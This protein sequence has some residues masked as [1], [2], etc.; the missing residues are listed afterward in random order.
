MSYFYTILT[1]KSSSLLPI[2]IV[3]VM[4]LNLFLIPP[5]GYPVYV[6]GGS[7]IIILIVFSIK[8]YKKRRVIK[9]QEEIDK[10]LD[11]NWEEEPHILFEESAIG[12]L[13]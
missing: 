6:I 9:K 1:R 8:I 2:I 3:L 7:I 4:T 12:K 13:V 5:R 10:E 11:D